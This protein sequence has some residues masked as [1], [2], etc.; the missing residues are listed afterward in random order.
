[1]VLYLFFLGK[2]SFCGLAWES[3]LGGNGYVMANGWRFC[4]G[5]FD[6]N[7]EVKGIY[8]SLYN[9]CLGW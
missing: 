9:D 7:G 8:K 6:E 2:G 3:G 4:P 5:E 1:M